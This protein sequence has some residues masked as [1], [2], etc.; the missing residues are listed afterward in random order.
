MIRHEL[1]ANHTG[2]YARVGSDVSYT[3]RAR[4]DRSRLLREEDASEQAVAPEQH[5][6]RSGGEEDAEGDE[7]E[8]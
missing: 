5:H 6:R 1:P 8:P 7:W 3:A 2:A 4:S